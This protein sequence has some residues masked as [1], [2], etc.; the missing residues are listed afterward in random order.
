MSSETENQSQSKWGS[1]AFQRRRFPRIDITLPVEYS[2]LETKEDNFRTIIAKNI[3]SGGLLLVLP[4]FQ[5]LSSTLKIR[6]YLGVKTIDAEVKVT[7]TELING[8]EKNEFRCGVFFTN[9]TEG[10]LESIKQFTVEYS[11]RGAK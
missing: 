8:R 9:I 5:P 4:E 11:E 2:P 7:W 10:D 6:I 1:V 3:S